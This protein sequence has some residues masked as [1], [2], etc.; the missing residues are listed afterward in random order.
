MTARQIQMEVCALRGVSRDKLINGG[1][2]PK[3]VAARGE[4]MARCRDELGMSY[5]QIGRLFGRH[6]TTVIH[7]IAKYRGE[8]DAAQDDPVLKRAV[9]R[10]ARV[11]AEQGRVI[12]A[13]AK[14]LE[15]LA[16]EVG[17][18]CAA[19]LR[20]SQQE[21]FARGVNADSA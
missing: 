12:A 21:L 8:P 9:A 13:Q 20:P 10:Q 3:L 14:Q 11:I 19:G 18:L 4:A 5:P 17:E 16:G 1:N 2:Q 7:A 15:A 6:H